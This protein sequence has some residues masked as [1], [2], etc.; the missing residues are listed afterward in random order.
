MITINKKILFILII[1]IALICFTALLFW[2]YKQELKNKTADLSKNEQNLTTTT[3]PATSSLKIYRNEEWGFEFE[4]PKDWRI[5]ENAF[6]SAVSMFNLVIE[7]IDTAHLPRPIRINVL[8]NDWIEQVQKSFEADGIELVKVQINGI[9]GIRY[10]HADE[11]LSQIDFL[12]SKDE[13][14]IVVGGKKKYIDTLNQVLGS[15]K[16][17]K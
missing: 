10:E 13:Y 12:I 3:T 5:K 9:D 1:L 4:Y 14:W 8:P 2:Q 16:F 7:Q 6:G 17:L 11:G 15:F